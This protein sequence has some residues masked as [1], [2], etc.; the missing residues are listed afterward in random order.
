MRNEKLRRPMPDTFADECDKVD[1]ETLRLKYQAG[2]S[3][4]KRWMQECGKGPKPREKPVPADFAEKAAVMGHAELRKLFH[5]SG[6]VIVRW[7][8]Q[9]GVSKSNRRALPAN[10]DDIAEG[11]NI[12]QIARLLDWNEV[13]LRN[14]L[15]RER[16]DLYIKARAVGR[17]MNTV[18]ARAVAQRKAAQQAKKPAKTGVVKLPRVRVAIIR[19]QA[20]PRTTADH[21]M[22]WLQRIGPCYPSRIINPVLDDYCFRGVRMTGTQ[23]VAEA[24]RRGWNPDAWREV[25]A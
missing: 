18:A 7:L 24:R 13:V 23:L 16:P 1:V 21:A 5:A 6:P 11:R 12:R 4:I 20:E 8:A 15:K 19:D 3:T 10:I 14:L 22:R 17:M 2:Y 9:I 25:A